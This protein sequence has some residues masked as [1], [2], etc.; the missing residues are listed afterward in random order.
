MMN[1]DLILLTQVSVSSSYV[2]E[3]GRS[4]LG[5]DGAMENGNIQLVLR[6]R[7]V[8]IEEPGVPSGLEKNSVLSPRGTGWWLRAS[9]AA[10]ALAKEAEVQG[11]VPAGTGV[12]TWVR[13]PG[14]SQGMRKI[15]LPGLWDCAARVQHKSYI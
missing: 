12:R 10:L 11:S 5:P 3:G 15:A 9:W 1:R 4:I 8:A 14:R 2:G 6:K 13:K 7:R